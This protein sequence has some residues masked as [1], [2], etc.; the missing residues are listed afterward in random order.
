MVA[1]LMMAFLS[2]TLHLAIPGFTAVVSSQ[3]TP[4]ASSISPNLNPANPEGSPVIV[5]GETV[6]LVK[7]RVG[8]FSRVERAK[9]IS[10][11]IR[12]VAQDPEITIEE[13]EVTAQ[14]DNIFV[15]A[16]ETIIITVTQADADVLNTT[17]ALLAHDYLRKI[18]AAIARYRQERSFESL[19]YAATYAAIATLVFIILVIFIGKLFQRLNRMLLTW[20]QVSPRALQIQRLIVLP[21]DKVNEA[22]VTVSKLTQLVIDLVLFYGYLTLVLR[23]FPWTRGVGKSLLGYLFTA[24]LFTLGKFVSYLPSLLIMIVVFVAAF[25]VTR[26]AKFIF[27]AVSRGAITIPGFYRDWADP[28]Y[29][30]TVILT[31]AIAIAIAYPYL[32]GFDTPAFRS[33][34]LLV[35]ALGAFGAKE[36]V[37]NAIAGVVLIYTRAFQVGDRVAV[38]DNVGT[39]M[40]KTLLVTRI[41]TPKNVVVTIPNSQILDSDVSNY[42]T[43]PTEKETP[44]V[45]H[46]GITLGY[47][48]P[49]RLVHEVLIDAANQTTNVLTEP[50]PF[51][52]QKSLD[53]FY[54]AYEINIST[55]L[56]SRMERIYS[57]LHQHI[58]DKC[59]EAGIEIL[60]PGYMAM[61]DGNQNTIPASYL[62]SG[63]DAPGFRIYPLNDAVKS[64][65]KS[66]NAPPVQNNRPEDQET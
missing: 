1:I 30:L 7:V 43:A 25:Y 32:P 55:N 8:E 18:Q 26:L 10:Q 44:L 52:L 13:V 42:S 59:N 56:P 11:R 28:T 57:E 39:V 34:S 24:T 41:M 33:I 35:G 40:E 29:R 51:V 38:G 9:I 66:T 65:I 31:Y 20:E 37:S 3:S 63:Y 5:D 48:V 14:D 2:L 53:D 45:L 60:S 12:S 19:R 46:T 62:P 47:D 49:W 16:P 6:F 21:A 50:E 4:A 27:S 23:A 36:A 64:D 61:R 54:V 15:S 17:R 22:L 58:Q